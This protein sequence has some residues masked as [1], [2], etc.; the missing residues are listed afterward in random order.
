MATKT[1]FFVVCYLPLWI[2]IVGFTLFDPVISG[3]FL[4]L[5]FKY[6]YFL[7]SRLYKIVVYIFMLL[8]YISIWFMVPIS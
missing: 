4:I 6:K 5:T 7:F 2:M 1:D 3:E 8:I